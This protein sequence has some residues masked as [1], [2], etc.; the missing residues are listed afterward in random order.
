[1]TLIARDEDVASG[2]EPAV[3]ALHDA[4]AAQKSAFRAAPYPTREQRKAHLEAL[5]GMMMSNR[6]RIREAMT[7]DFAVHPELF[8][9]LIEC[10]GIPSRAMYAISQLDQWMA[11][12]ERDTDPAI[13]GTAKA[14]VRPQPKGVIGNIV[15]WNFPFD[16]GVGPLVEMLA[17]GNRVIVKPSDFTPACGELLRDMLA[18]TFDADHVTTAVGGLELARTFPT[19]RWDHLLYTGSPGIGRVIAKAAAENLVPT[20]LELG[21]KCPA[22]VLDDAVD[23][24]TVASILGTKM[25]K[26]G[27]MCISV[28][29]VLVPRTRMAEF[30]AMAQ[31]YVREN[32]PQYSRS[33]DCTGII[34]TRHLDRLI[35]LREQA[36]DAGYEVVDLEEGGE[37]N[38]TTRQMPLVLV[39][40]PGDELGIMQE[41]IFGP[42]LPVKPYDSLD[43]AL[44]YIN[45]GERPLGLYVFGH[46]ESLTDRVLQTTSSGGAC[47]NT[48]AMQG[49][50]PS[51]G[52]GGIGNSGMGRHHGIDGFREFSN[53]RGVV[54]R[55]EDDL[56]D[57]FYPP[58]G[59]ALGA[60][61]DSA[62]GQAPGTV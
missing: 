18:S 34:T 10:V 25:I 51:L 39:L 28:D 36:R 2:D 7:A 42:L 24:K 4:L 53:P 6:Q 46:D 32:L 55:G 44:A 5:A 48:C 45:D 21:G 16:I 52:F 49:A 41:E 33:G 61:M 29:Y 14:F 58:Y 8:S 56:V 26:N 9:D 37:D 59:D 15:P 50:L 27:Q 43:E 54:V 17:A 62:F 20:T 31:Q 3:A 47:V 11:D 60:I 23:M 22:V 13:F 12:E 40:D 1:M 38:R 19:L 35:E 30:T 57:A